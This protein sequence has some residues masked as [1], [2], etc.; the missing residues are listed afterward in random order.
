MPLKDINLGC[1]LKIQVN[2]IVI[3][4]K[5][6]LQSIMRYPSYIRSLWDIEAENFQTKIC[7]Y[8]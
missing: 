3:Q 6:V 2:V 4:V 5:S 7:I 8:Y 1:K